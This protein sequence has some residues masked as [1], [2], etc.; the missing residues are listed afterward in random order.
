MASF[1]IFLLAFTAFVLVGLVIA[2]LVN[3]TVNSI[4]KDNVKAE[5]E[6]KNI[7]KDKE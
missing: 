5:K 1:V 7:K 4:E 2:K 3:S 6:I